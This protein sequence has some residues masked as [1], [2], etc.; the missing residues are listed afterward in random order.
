MRRSTPFVALALACALPAH[1][2]A[3]ALPLERTVRIGRP[4]RAVRVR[5]A[6]AERG[7]SLVVSSGGRDASA[8]LSIPSADEADV[9]LV[10]VADGHSIA[11]V[12]AR[13]GDA[14]AAA[15]VAVSGGRAEVLWTG[16]TDLHGDPGERV[17]DV[18]SLEDRTGDGRPDVVVGLVREGASL[19]GETGTL[20]FPRAFDPAQSAMR[21]VM[22][23]RVPQGGAEVTVTATRE[24]P[25]PSGPPLL[26]ALRFTGASSTSGRGED[27]SGAAAPR[28]LS[29]GDP[30]TFWAEGRGGAGAGEFVVGRFDASFPVRAVA[31]T[32]ASGPAGRAL[33]RPRRFWLVGD[34]G[35]R[36]RVTMPEDAA[37]RA[38][39]R[40]WI[41]LPEP[42]RWRCVALVLDEAYPP[43]GASDAAVRTGLAEIELYT[44]LD[45]GAGLDDLVA[46]LVENRG[47]G[48]EAARLLAALG[49]PAVRAV[50]EAWDRLDPLGRRRAVRVF[51]E[52]ARRGA[53]EGVAALA[54]AAR[55][56]APEV[57]DAALEALG[58]LGP[59]AGE[60]LAALVLEPGPLGDAAVRPLSRH[61]PAVVVRALLA[62]ITADGGSARPA[63]RDALAPA[64]ARG[65]EDARRAFEAWR[66]ADPPLA[67]RASAALGLAAHPRTRESAAVL[68]AGAVGTASTFEDRFRLVSAARHLDSDPEVDAWLAT[69]A[70]E[71]EEWMLRAAAL[72]ALGRRNAE[73]RI[74][75]ARR[76][77]EDPYPR[78]RAE[79]VRVLDA[80]DAADDAIAR[81]AARDAWPLVREAAVKAL[82]DR[83]AQRGVVR[84]AVR[85]RS[86]RVRRA[87]ILALARARDREAWPLVRARLADGQEWPEVTVAALRYVSE[88]CVRDA[89][90]V[91]AAVMRRGLSPQAWPPDVD[92]AALA[93]DVALL[94]GGPAAEEAR[95]L[96]GREDVPAGMR[97]ALRR[98]LERPGRCGE[99]SFF[100]PGPEPW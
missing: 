38:G 50:R 31:V 89:G 13:G 92:V 70:S 61:E 8:A 55:D 90:E 91:V 53:S 10:E 33:G 76:A 6:R 18:L 16:R 63:V 3:D 51:A 15:I 36:V 98:R 82:W 84:A 56:E 9:E 66:L 73:R 72:E 88:L 25:G 81:A 79:A 28:A 37:L 1:A 27:A 21:P 60:A 75:A 69:M 39:E 45:F 22:L 71:P 97:A 54:H 78:V 4:A 48:D 52:G 14:Q 40:Y 93:V 11:I 94:L 99:S 49:A 2:S 43:A 65:G 42:L 96:E 32:A 29:D 87:A 77:L 26:R 5:V 62:A 80:A 41:V 44:E 47:G 59:A 86:Q 68:V 12:R 67:A 95:R 83:P 46:I 23:R 58:A 30:A 35:P 100:N 57:R 64:L 20:L 34:A 24:S 19:C 7:A 74:E 17:A 85:D